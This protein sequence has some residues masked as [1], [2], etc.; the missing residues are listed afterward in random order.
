MS[1]VLLL[2]MGGMIAT[3]SAAEE[4]AKESPQPPAQLRHG[5]GPKMLEMGIPEGA[6]ITLWQPDLVTRQ[7]DAQHGHVVIPKTGMDNYHAVVA[8]K[9]SG[10]VKQAIIRYEY[11]R[12]KPSGHSTTELTAVQKTDFEIVPDPV[13]REHRHYQSGET[14]SFILRFQGSPVANIPVSLNTAHGNVVSG[15]SD[16][17]GQVALHI[18]DDFPDVQAG[19]RDERSAA[20]DVTAEYVTAGITYKTRLNSEYRVNPAHW[21]SLMLGMLVAGFGMIA[22]GVIGRAGLT[23]KKV[24][25]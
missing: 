24:R 20:F 14:W 15:T 2:S 8:E 23:K 16:K 7:L 1:L 6:T 19:E 25:S 21:K 18:P 3:A 17:S 4:A 11:Q 9:D 5:R 12:G 13:P 22:G 10:K